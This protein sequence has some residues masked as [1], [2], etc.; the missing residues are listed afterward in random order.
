MPSKSYA[1]ALADAPLFAPVSVVVHPPAFTDLGEPVVF[2]S[3]DEIAATLKPLQFA[4]VAKTPSGRPPFQEI[5]QLL[6]QHLTLG[7]DF[8]IAAMDNRHLLLRWNIGRV[9]HVALRTSQITNATA[10]YACVELDLLKDRPSR[11]WIGMGSTGFWQKILYQR[12][13]KYCTSCCLLGH[14]VSS[15]HRSQI[16]SSKVDAAGIAPLVVVPDLPSRQ[17]WMPMK[18]SVRNAG[19]SFPQSGIDE[20]LVAEG[21]LEASPM[22]LPDLAA[23]GAGTAEPPCVRAP[24]PSAQG[25]SELPMVPAVCGVLSSPGTQN[26]PCSSTNGSPAGVGHQLVVTAGVGE[27]STFGGLSVLIPCRT[28]APEKEA[29]GDGA[30]GIPIPRGILK[31]EKGGLSAGDGELGNLT[32][33]GIL[34]PDKEGLSAGE[35]AL[36][37]SKPELPKMASH[38]SSWA[39]FSAKDNGPSLGPK[40]V[41][42][43][44]DHEPNTCS[45]VSE[46]HHTQVEGVVQVEDLNIAQTSPSLTFA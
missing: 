29:A 2:F 35:D 23:S 39:I 25:N 27:P 43:S 1:R 17:Q 5:K 41:E 30:L 16:S 6:Q 33:R 11:V 44:A 3:S 10:A 26:P 46:Q 28:P 20:G 18:T 31:P 36:G 34:A 22:G 32:P 24:S 38:P 8:I 7:H 9:L 45:L 40:T 15:C 21:L 13:P 14:T 42:S 37:T 19:P 4:I 12:V